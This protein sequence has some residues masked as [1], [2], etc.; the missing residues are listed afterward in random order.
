MSKE[1]KNLTTKFSDFKDK[2][3][4]KFKKDKEFE[5][6]SD[7]II[8]LQELDDGSVEKIK[9]PIEIINITGVI[10]DDKKIKKMEEAISGGPVFST[11]FQT[12]EVK[13]GD[14][15]W[16]TAFIKK[17]GTIAWSAQQSQ[18]VLKCRIVDIYYG[19]NKLKYINQ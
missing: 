2:K 7:D 8:A 11:D 10:T 16:V 14:I 13:R 17:P 3:V 9:G 5:P 6:L 19:L 4:K 15:I 1:K 12:K 18:A